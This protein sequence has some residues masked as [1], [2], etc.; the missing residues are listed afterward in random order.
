MHAE[1]TT[2][3]MKFALFALQAERDRVRL[4]RAREAIAV[5]KLSG[6]VGTF[7]NMKMGYQVKFYPKDNNIFLVD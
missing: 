7:S 5:A 6:A 2:F 4:E 1:P 3:G